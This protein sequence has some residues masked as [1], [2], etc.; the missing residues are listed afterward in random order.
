MSNRKW[1]IAVIILFAGFVFLLFQF[2]VSALRIRGLAMPLA[3]GPKEG[4][5]RHHIVLIAQE[6]ENPYWRS[7]EQG[8][9]AASDKAGME[10][11]YTG[12]L[13]INPSEQITLLEKSIAAKADAVLLQGLADSKYRALI[14]K[15]ASQGI[16]VIAIDTDE[17]GSKRI[18]YVGT[19][20][21]EAGVRMGELVVRAA[22]GAG[23]IGVIV[24]SELAPNQQLRLQ[25]FRSV[26]SRYPN[27][28]IIEIR[29]SNISR[30][31]AAGQAEDL[32]RLYPQITDM[33]GFSAL[34][35]AG[36]AEAAGRVRADKLRV[37]AFD[38]A[39]ETL[40]GIRRCRIASTIVQQPN[41]M[42]AEAVS[43]LNDYFSGKQVAPRRVTAT[44]VLNASS[45]SGS[46]CR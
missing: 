33:V 13:R 43:L 6:L 29:S 23:R 38:A 45:V 5:P 7:I 10:L 46:A 21:E 30:L 34:D 12:P 15:A 1:S 40:E 20:N 3:P 19:D 18:S 32:L 28:S 36:I 39:E 11:E 35:G 44:S 8:A 14:D 41:E 37:F 25:G 16:P 42:G 31:Q 4:N 22:S 26:I 27:L 24:G 2:I 9:R 17:P